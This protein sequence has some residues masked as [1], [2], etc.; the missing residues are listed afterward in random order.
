MKKLLLFLLMGVNLPATAQRAEEH[1]SK[2]NEQYRKG[3]MPLAA[4]EYNKALR[5]DPE[6]MQA[7]LN[8]ANALFRQGKEVEAMQLFT[9]VATS[10]AAPDI[11]AKAWYN[12]GV[13]LSKQKNLKESIEAY[14]SALRIDPTDQQARENLQKALLELKKQEPPKKQD[15]QQKKNKQEEEK[16]K[17]QPQSKMS[18]KEAE[19]RLK[20]LQQKEKEVQEKVQQAK[21]KGGG[22]QGKDW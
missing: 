14:K 5:L 21:N 13:I 2:G 15:K 7:K 8:L 19:Q 10:K 17:Q 6:N 9:Q 1:I 11:K 12:K 20:L 22:T 18:P 3:V 4:E 16:K